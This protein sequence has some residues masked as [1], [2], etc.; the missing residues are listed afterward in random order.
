M[1]VIS[2]SGDHSRGM[3]VGWL[4]FLSEIKPVF[5]CLTG[6]G[7]TQLHNTS[8]FQKGKGN[9]QKKVKGYYEEILKTAHSE[10]II[11]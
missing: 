4:C 10:R 5:L 9:L 3:R 1:S 2:A 6:L 7:K 11:F 8:L